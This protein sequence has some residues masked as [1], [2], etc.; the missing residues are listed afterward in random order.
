[1]KWPTD[2]DILA[3]KL[4]DPEW[5]EMAMR[6][7]TGEG[8]LED[9]IGEDNLAAQEVEEDDDDEQPIEPW[10][11]GHLFGV[12]QPGELELLPELFPLKGGDGPCAVRT[13]NSARERQR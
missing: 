3:M 8:C 13:H 10:T 12:A 7:A 9:E 2:D 4:S 6:I 1:M 5:F 11:F